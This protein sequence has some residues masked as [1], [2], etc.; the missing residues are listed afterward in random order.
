M[1]KNRKK[2]R[3]NIFSF[4]RSPKTGIISGASRYPSFPLLCYD[5]LLYTHVLDDFF[6]PF[7]FS[8]VDPV[9]ANNSFNR[10][11]WRKYSII[12][13]CAHG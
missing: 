2:K 4:A 5:L 8:F 3:F 7:L 6:Q 12:P 9:N 1:R 10:F 13:F 11:I